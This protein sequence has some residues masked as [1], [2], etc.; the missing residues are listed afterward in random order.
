M[1]ADDE[2]VAYGK[3]LEAEAL[4]YAQRYGTYAGFE[5]YTADLA[6]AWLHGYA[7]GCKA[8][9]EAI[10]KAVGMAPL[11]LMHGDEALQ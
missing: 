8:A 3:A 10:R 6:A 5:H 11:A 7:A 4:A 9:R 1:S 2:Q